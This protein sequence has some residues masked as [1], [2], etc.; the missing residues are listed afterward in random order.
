[1]I[2]F[3]APQAEPEELRQDDP[4][5]ERQQTFGGRL[6]Q[7]AKWSGD[8]G[9]EAAEIAQT[10][11]KGVEKIAPPVAGTIH[12]MGA[13]ALKTL[14]TLFMGDRKDIDEKNN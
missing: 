3:G 11:A 4:I 10:T 1:M 9:A 7:L 8:R 6:N 5:A 2:T 13:A 14:K 12:H